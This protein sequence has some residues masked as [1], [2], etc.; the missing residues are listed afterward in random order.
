MIRI[1]RE[2]A[3]TR[4]SF[5]ARSA[6]LVGAAALPAAPARAAGPREI[7][8]APAPS[9]AAIV[10]AP[11]PETSVWAY[12]G[13]IPGPEIRVAQGE[14]LRIAVDNRLPAPTTVHWHGLRLPNAMDGVAHV[15]QEPIAPGARFVYAFDALDAGTF[16]YHPHYAS[17][18]Q[19]ERGLAGVLVVEEPEPLRVDR[20]LVWA[21]D[22]WRLDREA[23]IVEDFGN[24]MDTSH[25]GR[26]G[27]TV[28]LNGRVPGEI[29]VSPGERLRLRLVNVAN[30]RIFALRFADHAPVVVARDGHPVAPHEPKD[31]VVLLGPGM[32]VDL[33]LDCGADPGARASVVDVFPREPYRVVD[34]AYGRMP[35]RESPLD[36]PLALAPNPVPE[37]DLATALTREVVFEGGMMGGF[38][39]GP[40]TMRAMTSRGLAWAVNGVA[41]DGAHAM[42]PL[43]TVESGRSVVLDLVN[44]T[45]WWHPIHLHGH[46]FRILERDGAPEPHAPLADTALMAPRERMRIAFVAEGAGAWLLHCHVLE[47]Q[48]G[49][50]SAVLRVV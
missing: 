9:R 2:P 45:A 32:R 24:G 30:A 11:Y 21:L 40:E 44:E 31:G 15:T 43:L 35:L 3:L 19:L 26:L 5:L 47:H 41:D 18:E 22:D 42:P 12:D 28:T 49:G 33:V 34:L 46:A 17:A 16:W 4:R 36:A 20:D 8:L 50:M 48:A 39:G 29:A 6:A 14:R 27:N 10:G 13:R 7:T 38:R 37:P 1:L 23:A 25:A